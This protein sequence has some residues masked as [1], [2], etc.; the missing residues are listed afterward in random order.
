M[1]LAVLVTALG[2]A[3]DGG[4]SLAVSLE[5]PVIPYHRQAT[6]RIVAEAPEDAA[7]AFPSVEDIAPGLALADSVVGPISESLP[8][9]R[10]RVTLTCRL[11]ALWQGDYTLR[12]VTASF[13]A[14]GERTVPAPV[15]SVRDLT[16]AERAAVAQFAPNA[17]P[18]GPPW[19]PWRAWWVWALAGLG[20]ALALFGGVFAYRRW[21]Y[22]PRVRPPK[23]PWEVA[24][25]RLRALDEKRLPEAGQYGLFYIQLSAILRAYVEDR[26]H[27]HAPEQT[28]EEFLEEAARSGAV[29][30]AHQQLLAEFLRHCDR[31]KFA[32]LEPTVHDMEVSMT[33]VLRFIDETV[34][35]EDEAAEDAA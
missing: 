21:R 19:N 12:P 25:D 23:P 31:V 16:E 34:P 13:G 26:F 17:E 6:L 2:A 35:H 27:L 7:V 29:N 1:M 24:Y 15:L 22:R 9:G 11:D 10:K 18:L 28:T 14:Y 20:L 3:A 30:D 5:P 8:G 4:V 32:R 33:H